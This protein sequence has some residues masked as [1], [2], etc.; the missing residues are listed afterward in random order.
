MCETRLPVFVFEIKNE[1]S[2]L[3]FVA[4]ISALHQN[5][6]Q[7]TLFHSKCYDL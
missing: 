3:Q 4:K 2:I 6:F 7:N 5:N 1:N